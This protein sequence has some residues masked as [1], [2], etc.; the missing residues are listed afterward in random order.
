MTSDRSGHSGTV[1]I[2]VITVTVGRW[3]TLARAVESVQAQTFPGTITH[4]IVVDGDGQPVPA[5]PVTAPEQPIRF[6]VVP[7]PPADQPGGGTD[8]ASVYP[9]LARLLNIGVRAA[10]ARWVSFLD[11]DNEFEPDHLDSLVRHARRHDAVA[12]H[13]G[14]QI[15][16]SNG[17]PYLDPVFPWAADLATG[18]RIHALLTS[19]GVWVP[20][21]NL[22]LDQVGPEAPTFRNSTVME[23]SDPTF[24]IDQNVWLLRRE[25]MLRLP[26]PE[27]FTEVEIAENTC[28]DDKLLEVL[29]R[30]GVPLHSTGAPTVRYFLGGVS[31]ATTNGAEPAGPRS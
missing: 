14:R 27:H 8:R 26:F 17:E 9:R 22:L 30:N 4:L 15:V 31:N 11:D 16:W 19:R 25:L 13:S 5:P 28:P 3:E 24:L 29:V 2:C 21:T 23:D 6:H 20:G 7:R 1:D 18:R 10:D 12:V